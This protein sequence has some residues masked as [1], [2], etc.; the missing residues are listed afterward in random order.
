MDQLGEDGLDVV[1]E[2]LILEALPVL[3]IAD[4]DEQLAP[5]PRQR[6][7]TDGHVR[8][9]PLAALNISAHITHSH[10]HTLLRTLVCWVTFML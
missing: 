10:P 4:H 6:L 1:V 2:Q 5:A 3:R 7:P 9:C 8:L